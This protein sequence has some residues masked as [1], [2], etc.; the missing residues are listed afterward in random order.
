ME[1]DPK[2]SFVPSEKPYFKRSRMDFDGKCGT[3]APINPLRACAYTRSLVFLFI[4]II[5][6]LI[7]NTVP[8]VPRSIFDVL[9]I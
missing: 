4:F 3:N 1:R 5:F 9:K 8:L 6:L 2:S 7:A